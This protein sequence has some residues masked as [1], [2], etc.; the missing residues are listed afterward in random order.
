MNVVKQLF[1]HQL[2]NEYCVNSEFREESYIALQLWKTVIGYWINGIC[3]PVIL[4]YDSSHQKLA[5]SVVE[6]ECN[7]E[8]RGDLHGYGL[9]KSTVRG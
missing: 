4:I 3:G 1:E 8:N 5:R 9:A 6:I 2:T 7:V